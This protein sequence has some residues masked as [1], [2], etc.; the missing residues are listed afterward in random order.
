MISRHSCH[1]VGRPVVY[2]T[3]MGVEGVTELLVGVPLR[4]RKRRYSSSKSGHVTKIYF[5]FTTCCKNILLCK[6]LVRMSAL[7]IVLKFKLCDC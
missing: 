6:K 2:V 3:V 7:L 4:L 5:C 1:Q